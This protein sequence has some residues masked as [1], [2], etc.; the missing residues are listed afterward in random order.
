[1]VCGSPYAQTHEMFGGSRRNM[2]RLF[3]L[4]VRLCLEHH[5]GANGVHG[6]DTKL[7]NDIE[8]MGQRMFERDHGTRQDFMRLFGGRNYL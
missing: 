7:R 8:Q 2:S 6:T 1:M 4:T 5:T 3:G